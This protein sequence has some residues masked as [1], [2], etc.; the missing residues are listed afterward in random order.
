MNADG[1]PIDG[2][3]GD[4]FVK[5]APD[6]STPSDPN[7]NGWGLKV[8]DYFT[9]SDQ[10]TLDANDE[11][12]GSG[13]PMLLP[14]SAGDAAHPDLLIGAGKEGTIYLID[15]NDM[16]HY[17]PN[18]DKVVQETGPGTIGMPTQ[19]YIGGSFGTAAYFDGSF[20]YGGISDYI[21]QFS[22]ANTAFNTT[23]TSESPNT[24]GY[25]GTTPSISAD[26]GSDGILWRSTTAPTAAGARRCSTPTTPPTSRTSSTAARRPAGR[27]TRPGRRS[28]SPCR[29]SPTARSTSAARDADNLRPA[30]GGGHT[31]RA[32]ESHGHGVIQNDQVSQLTWRDKLRTGPDSRS[33]RRPTTSTS[34]PSQ[35]SGRTSTLMSL[36][37]CRPRPSTTTR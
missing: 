18:G 34:V 33:G 5:V 25:P 30:G 26:G 12:L 24:F 20:Y 23:P 4:S 1:F 22:V 21:K 19:Y 16:G 14:A 8:V 15:C 27:A 7:I 31:R 17:D 9:P 36:A 28:S 2:D 11:D 6:S 10:A 35:R 29:R 13:G 3:Y 37:I 32:L